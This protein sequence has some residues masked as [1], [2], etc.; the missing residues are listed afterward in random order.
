MSNTTQKSQNMRYFRQLPGTPIA[1]GLGGWG[2]NKVGIKCKKMFQPNAPLTHSHSLDG[3]VENDLTIYVIIISHCKQT[4]LQL[5]LFKKL[6]KG[7]NT[8]IL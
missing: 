2:P 3:I 6:Q 7:L 1:A 4:H 8:F 5:H